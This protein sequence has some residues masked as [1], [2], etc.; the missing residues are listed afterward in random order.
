MFSKCYLS[1]PLSFREPYKSITLYLTQKTQGEFYVSFDC[2]SLKEDWSK[3]ISS[4]QAYLR[5]SRYVR[6][7]LSVSL[8]ASFCGSTSTPFW[9]MGGGPEP[10]MT[11]LLLTPHLTPHVDCWQDPALATPLF[12]VADKFK[13]FEWHRSNFSLA[14]RET[15]GKEKKSKASLLVSFPNWANLGVA[16]V[17]SA[18]ET[19]ICH[20]SLTRWRDRNVVAEP[21]QGNMLAAHPKQTCKIQLLQLQI[22]RREDFLTCNFE[23]FFFFTCWV[24]T[25]NSRALLE[26]WGSTLIKYGPRT[27]TVVA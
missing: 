23:Q 24:K 1:L 20:S 5:S 10:F 3:N 8:W 16:S 4:R 12:W 18:F 22:F 6:N 14:K 17:V 21:T 27:K 15:Q 9:G 7:L 19:T 25:N 11:F 13:Y 2:Q 26:K